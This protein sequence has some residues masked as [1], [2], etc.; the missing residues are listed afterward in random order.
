MSGCEV[1]VCPPGVLPDLSCQSCALNCRLFLSTI[2]KVT[3][4]YIYITSTYHLHYIYITYMH[5]IYIY[6]LHIYIYIYIY[7]TYIHYIYTLH[8]YITL[9]FI[10]LH[11]YCIAYLFFC[12]A[13]LLLHPF[14]RC[15][16]VDCIQYKTL[17]DV[18]SHPFYHFRS[19]NDNGST[20]AK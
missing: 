5:Y 12:V 8:R 19:R 4:H 18:R 3:L 7:I 17:N 2:H 14:V 15:P 11:T 13:Y 20:E 6:T 1:A 10:A 9:H 16:I